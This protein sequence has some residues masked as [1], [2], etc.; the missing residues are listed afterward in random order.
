MAEL[1]ILALLN[2]KIFK[3]QIYSHQKLAFA[4]N[5]ISVILNIVTV[6]FTYNEKN[7]KKAIYIKYW[8]TVFIGIFVYLLYSFFL[9]FTFI[10]IKKLIDLKFVSLHIILFLYGFFGFIFCSIFCI[11]TTFVHCE[12]ESAKYIFIISDED[13]KAYIDSY[14]IYYN[15]WHTADSSK[16]LYEVIIIIFGRLFFSL[17]KLLHS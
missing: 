5:F 4:I 7:E 6:I 16:K 17:Y 10:N 8:W 2:L 3:I 12:D 9:S 11:I 15:N 13:N 1:Y 14:K